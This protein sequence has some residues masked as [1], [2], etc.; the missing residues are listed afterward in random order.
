[1]NVVIIED[2]KLAAEKLENTL[3][4]IDENIH[5]MAKIGSV[6]EAVRWLFDNHPDLIFLDITSPTD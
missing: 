2:E 3:H 1:M 6:K 4:R 5:V